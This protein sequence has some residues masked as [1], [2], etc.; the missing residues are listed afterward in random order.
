MQ[1]PFVIGLKKEGDEKFQAQLY[2][3]AAAIYTMAMNFPIFPFMDTSVIAEKLLR[4]RATCFFKMVSSSLY[5]SEVCNETLE[6]NFRVRR[7]L[8]LA[9][10]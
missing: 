2:Q 10:K 5:T 7:A 1:D 4:K 3:E 6:L 9:L 8:I